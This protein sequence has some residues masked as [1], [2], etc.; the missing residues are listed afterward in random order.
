MSPTSRTILIFWRQGKILA[1]VA[2]KTV[3][4][5]GI[6]D[7]LGSGDG[8][9]SLLSRRRWS[10]GA[11][12]PS[13]PRRPGALLGPRPSS[14]PRRCPRGPGRL[15]LPGHPAAGGLSRG[16]SGSP[17]PLPCSRRPR[18]RR[19]RGRGSRE[20]TDANA[21]SAT[22]A[23]PLPQRRRRPGPRFAANLSRGH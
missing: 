10:A 11:P 4:T 20:R 2:R 7:N 8:E 19:E 5:C 3:K 15:E 12:G 18:S 13:L 23:A 16:A 9:G 22:R 21:G 17:H 6:Q 1:N 14:G